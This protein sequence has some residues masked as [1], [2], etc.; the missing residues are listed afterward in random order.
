MLLTPY[1]L[2]RY[3]PY[4]NDTNSVKIFVQMK[5]GTWDWIVNLVIKMLIKYRFVY[6]RINS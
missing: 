3:K 2:N 4:K 5:Y 6:G 1:N